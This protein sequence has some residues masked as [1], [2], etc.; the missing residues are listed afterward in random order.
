[1]TIEQLTVERDTTLARLESRWSWCQANPTHPK[2]DERT[3][4]ALADLK[5]YEDLEDAIAVLAA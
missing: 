1:M 5:A 4:A 3:D 2:I